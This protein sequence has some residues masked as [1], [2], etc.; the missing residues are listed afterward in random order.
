MATADNQNHNQNHPD[1]EA[2]RAELREQKKR[3]YQAYATRQALVERRIEEHPD[4]RYQPDDEIQRAVN[5]QQEL[6]EE[7]IALTSKLVTQFNAQPGSE[8]FHFLIEQDPILEGILGASPI[9]LA[10]KK[11]TLR[12][13]VMVTTND[14]RKLEWM[15]LFLAS[16]QYVGLENHEAEALLSP[17]ERTLQDEG[18]QVDGD[19][20]VQLIK[21]GQLIDGTMTNEGLFFPID[22]PFAF[23]NLHRATDDPG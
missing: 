9:Q 22:G 11:G 14:G 6:L 18:Y 4:G 2:A 1:L 10:I 16:G 15:G 20:D 8:V 21:D 7:L 13:P 23:L 12:R 3:F 17:R 5:C 19:L